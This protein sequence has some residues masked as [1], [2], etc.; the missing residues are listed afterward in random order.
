M[1]AMLLSV[2]F[3]QNLSGQPLNPFQGGPNNY[4]TEFYLSF[5]ANLE[6]GNA[7][8]K[9]VRLYISSPVS[10]NV[11]IYALGQYKGSVKTVPNDIVT[12]D[13]SNVEAQILVRDQ[14]S[15]IVDDAIYKDQSVKVL[16]DDPIVIYGM[17]RTSF[18]SDGM[19]ILPVNALGKTYVVA[20]TASNVP[21]PGVQLPSQ[22]M[23]I[24]PYD[25]TSVE[26]TNPM[27]TPNHRAGET[28]TIT[29]NEGDVFSAMSDGSGGDLSGAVISADKP[30]AVTAGQNCAYLPDENFRACDH[31]AEM[32]TPVES[33]GT[34]YHAIPFQ[35]RTR[36]DTYRVFAGDPDADI[37]VNDTKVATLKEVGGQNGA[38]WI[39]YREETRRPLEFS[40]NKR[41]F[42]AQYNNSQ[43]YD[44]SSA[45]DPFYTI[46][47]PVKQYQEGFVFSTPGNTFPQYFLSIVGDSLAIED[48][49]IS[50]AGQDDWQNVLTLQGNVLYNFPNQIDGKG[51][52]G[53]GLTLTPGTYQIRSSGPLAGYIYAG[54]P[55]DSFGYPL[56]ANMANLTVDD[57]E[58]PS[59]AYGEV[60]C[61][62]SVTGTVTDFPEAA[63]Q[64][65]NLASVRLLPESQNF[66]L[67]VEQY[68]V[69]LSRSADFEL[70]AIDPGKSAVGIL[71]VSDKAGNIAHDT[72]KY[73]APEIQL[74]TEAIDFGKAKI[75]QPVEMSLVV[76]NDGDLAY[77]ITQLGLKLENPEFE[78]LSPDPSQGFTLQPGG[79]TSVT[80]RF[81]AG[82]QG[83]SHDT[84][85]IVGECDLTWAVP[86]TAT[87]SGSGRIAVSDYDFNRVK[88]GNKS[89]AEVQ[90]ENIGSESLT[91]IG[92]RGPRAPFLWDEILAFPFELGA[93][94]TRQLKVEFQPDEEATY[95]DSIV[96]L[97]DAEG[98]P[99]NDPVAVLLG[100]GVIISSVHGAPSDQDMRM[101]LSSNPVHQEYVTLRYM[102]PIGSTVSVEIT[103]MSGEK[104]RHI[105]LPRTEAGQHQ[106]Q[107]D[108]QD[109]PS[110]V[111]FCSVIANGMRADKTLTILR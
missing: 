51:Y 86:I 73:N 12:F 19:L 85:L 61:D 95:R 106:Y 75:N 53:V 87:V 15:P 93:G 66:T 111:Y 90:I 76:L 62:G 22:Y 11:D 46:L 57:L 43:E 59:V 103:S 27:D 63:G 110:G 97:H 40:S 6:V 79:Q 55:F 26:I 39:E 68:V 37:Y 36:G 5:P 20:S 2:A 94:A 69:G 99:G 64:R 54:G 70:Q 98:V 47:T 14:T 38:G 56:S 77:S 24:A 7:T 78:I 72:V 45:S 28:F 49:E 44:G 80:V 101:E 74:D 21:N 92:I 91:I 9:F 96:V 18:T 41:I 104:V 30:V 105:M 108:V 10:T 65:A 82:S 58:P 83:T 60:L 89:T 23:I 102:L 32:L 25:N 52:A 100:E 71:A 29:L 67:T 13:L 1:L 48:A 84:L 4:G 88:V 31:I 50:P 81:L 17:N 16:A 34:F 42:V 107:I 109:I 3:A 33:W 8:E 35:N